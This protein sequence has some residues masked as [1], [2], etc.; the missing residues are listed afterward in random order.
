MWIPPGF[1]HGFCV[2]SDEADFQYKCTE[3]YAPEHERTVL[4][5]DPSIGVAWPSDRPLLSK[6]DEAALPLS[7]HSDLPPFA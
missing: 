2:I 7:W 6:K 4:W 3:T 1:A 5:N